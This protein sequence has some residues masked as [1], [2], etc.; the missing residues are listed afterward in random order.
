MRRA[1][2]RFTI[3]AALVAILAGC[4]GGAPAVMERV[5]TSTT[6]VEPVAPSAPARYL[7]LPAAGVVWDEALS[8]AERASSSRHAPAMALIEGRR[9]VLREGAIALYL[10]EPEGLLGFRSV[11]AWLGGG[12]VLWSADQ[13]F[14][15]PTFEGELTGVAG[16]GAVGGA[17]PWLDAMLLRTPGGLF[18]LDVAARSARRIRSPA[19][20]EGL[21]LAPDRA[22]RLDPWGR[23]ELTLD[24]R[25]WRSPGRRVVA[26]GL[27]IQ[28]GGILISANPPAWLGP[29]G[30]GLAPPPASPSPPPRVGVPSGEAPFADAWSRWAV[31]AGA[32]LDA[33]RVVAPSDEGLVVLDAP[34]G[35][36]RRVAVPDAMR[37]GL[38]SCRAV[39]SGG[40]VLL[41]C[42]HGRGAHV[43]RLDRESR[44]TPAL[45]VTLPPGGN[46]VGGDDRPLAYEG[47]CGGE[48]P[49]GADFTPSESDA[50]SRSAADDAPAPA[51]PDDRVAT[52]CVRVAAGRWVE[53]SVAGEG[54]RSFYTWVPAPDGEVVAVLLASGERAKELVRASEGVRVVRVD[55]GALPGRLPDRRRG[56]WSRAL[57][58]DLWVDDEGAIRG[59]LEIGS[60]EDEAEVLAQGPVPRMLPVV[61]S[62]GGPAAGVTIAIDGR[63]AV[64]PAPAGA[65]AFIRGGRFAMALG[66]DGDTLEAFETTDG[67]RSWRSVAPPPLGGS[68]LEEV[69]RPDDS[70]C[71][72]VGCAWANGVVR[73]GWG[74]PLPRT[75]AARVTDAGAARPPTHDARPWPT[76]RCAGSLPEALEGEAPAQLVRHVVQSPFGQQALAPFAP[77]GRRLDVRGIDAFPVTTLAVLPDRAHGAFGLGLSRPDGRVWLSGRAE[78]R[79]LGARSVTTVA[80]LGSSL[81][82]YAAG[83]GIVT[84]AKGGQ[85]LDLTR[86]PLV[87]DVRGARTTLA[88][89]D[90]GRLGLVG[91]APASGDAWVAPFDVESV[92]L[93]PALGLAAL[94]EA[95]A[96]GEGACASAGAGPRW[97]FVAELPARLRMEGGE[98]VEAEAAMFLLSA[99]E[100]SVCVEA[101]ELMLSE[102]QPVL[103]TRF[104]RPGCGLSAACREPSATW[105]G[106]RAAS[107]E[108]A[109]G[110]ER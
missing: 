73:W 70:R 52:V 102:R 53:R 36:P 68:A 4:G 22:V 93:G 84:V 99:S 97:R 7:L 39:R 81:L 38:D 46:F 107:P 87:P 82:A 90:D 63:V 110:V 10:D 92:S 83:P 8:A 47:R 55:P 19:M 79:Q 62:T 48:A 94:D 74:G 16:M 88:R 32:I 57:E 9:A 58:D 49:S 14:Y 61:P 1:C 28:G 37:P 43:V 75:R 35:L 25:S 34:T 45:E 67:G 96:W 85:L 27:E 13:T 91:Y 109:F 103:V 108:C 86:F 15:A 100:T 106:A 41:A 24:G 65:V 29:E 20:A 64:H 50:G 40:D 54:A 30:A 11:P 60:S 76:L 59:W 66:R 21:A 44:M 51:L 33:E 12:F 89:A 69:A 26:D 72:E 78:H 77:V 31:L 95:A 71:T 80:L 5:G 105:V 6:Q 42:V 101:V 23:V 17:R 56:A 3:G 104:A 2:D 98:G 18:S